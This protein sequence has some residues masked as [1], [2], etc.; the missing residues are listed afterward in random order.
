MQRL[1]NP[2]RITPIRRRLSTNP[3]YQVN[4]FLGEFCTI[5]EQLSQLSVLV[6]ISVHAISE[7][8]VKHV[9]WMA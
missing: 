6:K 2:L 1:I 4:F 7:E 3:N 8:D 9:P 5:N